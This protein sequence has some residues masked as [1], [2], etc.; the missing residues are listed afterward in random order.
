[1]VTPTGDVKTSNSN[2]LSCPTTQ[3]TAV[4]NIAVFPV[5]SNRETQDHSSSDIITIAANWLAKQ[6]Y[7]YI[8]LMRIRHGLTSAE[9][10]EAVA[11]YQQITRRTLL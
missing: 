4:D 9:V 5:M 2:A 1:L 11:E 3:N 8:D 6:P 7:P 10:T